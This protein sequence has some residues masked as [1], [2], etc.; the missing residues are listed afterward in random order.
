MTPEKLLSLDYQRDAICQIFNT[1]QHSSPF[2]VL[3]T[4][5]F[6]V[7]GVGLNGRCGKSPDVCYSWWTGVTMHIVDQHFKTTHLLS[8]GGDQPIHEK[9]RECKLE[10]LASTHTT[11]TTLSESGL[12]EKL[13][14]WILQCQNIETG[15][16]SRTPSSY[17]GDQG[18]SLHPSSTQ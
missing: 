8:N 1:R 5:P 4:L 2:L 12:R 3:F 7:R 17:S 9:E 13:A 10:P 11:T 15:G 14:M 18:L 16:F 6:V